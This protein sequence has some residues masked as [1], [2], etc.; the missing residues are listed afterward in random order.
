VALTRDTAVELFGRRGVH[1]VVVGP[2]DPAPELAKI[3]LAIATIQFDLPSAS[4]MVMD[5]TTGEELDRRSFPALLSL[6]TAVEATTHVV[7]F[8]VETLLNPPPRRATPAKAPTKPMEPSPAPTYIAEATPTP[9][10]PAHPAGAAVRAGFDLGLAVSVTSLGN[11]ELLPGAGLTGELRIHGASRLKLGSLFSA[12]T[13]TP[14]DLDF[15]TAKARLRSSQFRLLGM[16]DLPV[17]SAADFSVGGGAALE[18]LHVVPARQADEIAVTE[19]RSL[20]KPLLSAAAGVRLS[21]GKRTVLS[22]LGG[23]DVGPTKSHFVARASGARQELLETPT[24]RPLFL[25]SASTSL[26][27][28]SRFAESSAD[29]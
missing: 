9:P 1:V 18:W 16:L 3:P 7:Y 25:L 2:H 5:G 13:H 15:A 26:D 11:G 29:Q 21:L 17:S 4:S 22:A 14:I 12:T 19:A 20:F 23:V 10:S 27:E 6:E 24:W 28:S 8:V